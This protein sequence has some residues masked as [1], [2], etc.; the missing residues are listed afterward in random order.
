[1]SKHINYESPKANRFSR[2]P[3]EQRFH[4]AWRALCEAGDGTFLQEMLNKGTVPAAPITQRDA[5]VATLTIQWLGSPIG[6]TWLKELGYTKST[7]G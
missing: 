6:Q 1:M 2:E 3:E 7:G 5:T 4:T